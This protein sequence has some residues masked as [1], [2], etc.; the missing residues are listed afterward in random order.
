MRIGLDFDNTLAD[1]D[2]L[3][4]EKLDLLPRPLSAGVARGLRLI[5]SAR[6]VPRSPAFRAARFLDTAGLDPSERYGQ[7]MEMFP[8][9]LRA[10]LW[11]PEALAE[12]RRLPTAGELL[13]AP[14][15][16]GIAEIGRAH[17]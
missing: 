13:G 16:R 5:P 3:F 7:I 12:L 14:R 4:A 17:V 11:T 6:T 15:G 2:A 1:Y 10:D 9:P 8:T